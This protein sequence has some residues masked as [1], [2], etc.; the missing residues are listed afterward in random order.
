[1]LDGSI[2]KT[3]V[4]SFLSPTGMRSELIKHLI[5]SRR[6]FLVIQKLT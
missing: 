5:L 2:V 3:K 4:V 1:M 6:L